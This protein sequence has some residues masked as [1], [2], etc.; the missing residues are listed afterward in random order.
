MTHK[1][2]ITG[3]PPNWIV[4]IDGKPLHIT[5][6]DLHLDAR[7]LPRATVTPDIWEPDVETEAIVQVP[8]HTRDTLIALGWTPPEDDG[9]KPEMSDAEFDRRLT[10]WMRVNPGEMHRW[11]AKRARIHGGQPIGR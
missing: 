8:G 4:E 6:I 3:K 9:R 7:S 2:S 10:V 11:L 1:L 5:E